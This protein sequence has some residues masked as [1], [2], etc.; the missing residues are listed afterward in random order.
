MSAESR[1][2]K[3][4]EWEAIVQASQGGQAE[5]NALLS[6]YR[7]RLLRM[8]KMRLDNRVQGRVDASDVI[9][10]S[11]IE[12]GRR[13]EEYLNDPSVPFFIWL[14]YLTLQKLTL[15]HR[16]HLG[17]KA[18]DANREVSLYRGPSPAATSAALAAQLIGQL[19]TPSQ[20]AVKAETK[21]RLQEAL[22]NMDEIDREVLALRH[23]EQLSQKETAM[24]LNIGQKAAG[25]RH[26]RTLA[27][28][29]K[30]LNQDQD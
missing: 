11:Y 25:A 24:V 30:I 19:S 1:T 13:I 10:E 7:D 14:R 2:G 15:A 6:Q 26:L 23:F 4:V 21:T 9:Q 3:S 18:R 28:L 17:V 8:V 16:Q 20:A 5:L 27:R 22:N 29:K 12:A